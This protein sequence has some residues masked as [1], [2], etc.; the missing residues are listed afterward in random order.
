[1]NV[2]TLGEVATAPFVALLFIKLLESINNAS[3]LL[4]GFL[5]KSTEPTLPLLL[6]KIDPSMYAFEFPSRNMTP[7]STFLLELFS[8]LDKLIS[9]T[10]S[11]SLALT[12]ITPPSSCACSPKL[13]LMSLFLKLE[14]ETLTYLELL[15]TYIAEP[16]TAT[17]CSK[18]HENIASI[19]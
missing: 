15:P 2:E 5:I 1:M 16:L 8:K 4:L 12:Y 7:P 19:Y 14:R 6:V 13:F 9:K 18:S 10:A 11:P 17:F 3:F